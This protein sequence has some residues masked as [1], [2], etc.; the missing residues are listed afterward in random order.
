MRVFFSSHENLS[1]TRVGLAQTSA[2][3]AK[4]RKAWYGRGLRLPMN[5]ASSA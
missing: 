2:T 5:K 3:S 1:R 4:R